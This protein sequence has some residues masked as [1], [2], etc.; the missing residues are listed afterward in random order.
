[1]NGTPGWT[2][3]D[4]EAGTRPRAGGNFLGLPVV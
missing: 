2:L 3:E 1:M 4:M